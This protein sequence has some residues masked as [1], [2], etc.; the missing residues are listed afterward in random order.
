M[1]DSTEGSLS[2]AQNSENVNN[3]STKY[4]GVGFRQVKNIAVSNLNNF[5]YID[6]SD[7]NKNKKFKVDF[8]NETEDDIQ[9]DEDLLK[10]VTLVSVN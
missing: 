4:D 9:N 8:V 1:L 5:E 6:I 2:G 10:N 3:N 7:Y